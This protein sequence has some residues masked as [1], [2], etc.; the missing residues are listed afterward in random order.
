MQMCMYLCMYLLFASVLSQDIYMVNSS[1]LCV[2]QCAYIFTLY[3]GFA[4]PMKGFYMVYRWVYVSARHTNTYTHTHNAQVLT[5]FLVLE[6]CV[7]AFFGSMST[8]RSHF[9]PDSLQVR[10]HACVYTF[11]HE[12]RQYSSIIVKQLPSQAKQGATQTRNTAFVVSRLRDSL[13]EIK[14]WIH[15]NKKL[16]IHHL[17]R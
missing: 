10:M 3:Y 2:C 11:V 9:L 15:S 13:N 17:K 8:M 16:R 5:S 12:C 4:D 7:G 14:N 6:V 1:V